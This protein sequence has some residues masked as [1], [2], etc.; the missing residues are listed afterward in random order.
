MV[1][2]KDS[3]NTGVSVAS[4]YTGPEVIVLLTY[5]TKSLKI[6]ANKKCY[7]IGSCANWQLFTECQLHHICQKNVK[8]PLLGVIPNI[9]S[10][11]IHLWQS[12]EHVAGSVLSIMV[13]INFILPLHK[14]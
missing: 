13:R 2:A 9:T 4:E 1:V 3:I 10:R 6:R 8:D 14:A 5:F 7:V 12:M 11:T